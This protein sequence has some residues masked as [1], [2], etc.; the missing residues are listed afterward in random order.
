MITPMWKK[1]PAVIIAEYC[2]H[3]TPYLTIINLWDTQGAYILSS[4]YYTLKCGRVEGGMDNDES[5]LS[6][7]SQSKLIRAR[8]P[9]K[10]KEEPPP[11]GIAAVAKSFIDIYNK[12]KS[13]KKKRKVWEK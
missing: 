13:P 1:R 6:S 5:G 2:K 8:N 11:S 10:K 7:R 4:T 12:C 3:R 9:R